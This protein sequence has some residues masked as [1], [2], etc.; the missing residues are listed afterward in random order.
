MMVA[1]SGAQAGGYQISAEVLNGIQQASANTGVDF[2]FLMAQ[3]AK[4]SGFNP[5][6]KAK[7]SS[8]SGLYQF[9][10]Q[11]WLSV[12]RKHGAEYGLGDMASKIKIADDGKLV[13]ADRALRKEILDLRRD[14][15]IAAAMAAE[16]AADNQTRLDA[17][18]DR[19][20]KPVDLYLAHF[21][22]LQGAVNFLRAMDENPDQSA[23]A[24]SPRAAGANKSIFYTADGTPRSLKQIYE[25]F[26]ARMDTEMAAYDDLDDALPPTMLADVRPSGG[27]G[28]GL[29]A[30]GDRA[31]Y[32]NTNPGGILSPFMLVTLAQLPTARDKDDN[33]NSSSLFDKP[34]LTAPSA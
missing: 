7:T 22:G 30:G 16:H 1:I 10:E 5:E 2:S 25:R 13:V 29:A 4:E 11:T 34:S 9:V 17:K 20:V 19:D 26:E 21:L 32:G 27:L 28:G 18:L 15:E 8:A 23:A 14:P 31:V 6:A 12:V 3:A 33:V 24:I